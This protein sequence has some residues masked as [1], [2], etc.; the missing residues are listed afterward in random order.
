MDEITTAIVNAKLTEL[1]DKLK[2]YIED[3]IEDE[4]KWDL[5]FYIDQLL[6]EAE[7]DE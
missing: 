3:E 5:I 2:E 4:N 6:K 7:K 1:T